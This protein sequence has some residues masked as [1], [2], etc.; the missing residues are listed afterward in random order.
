ILTMNAFEPL[1][2]MGCIYVLIRIIQ[3]FDSRLWIGFGALAGLGLM[4][5]HS[6]A[7]FGVA[8]VIGLLLTR[9]RK[10]FAKP[11]IWI[12]GAIALLIF[13]PNLFWQ[14]RHHSPTVEDLHNVRVTGK[15]VVLP[16]LQFIGQ[17]ILILNPVLFVV[18]IAGLWHFLVGGGQR[19]R[20]LGWIFLAFFSTMLV[21]HGKDYYVAPIYPILFAGG[22]VAWAN[23]LGKWRYTR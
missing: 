19:F 17:Q 14:I 10:E 15:N 16:P 3:T 6:T 2:W 9:Q 5:K 13:S 22:S 12:G 8:T 11:W 18:W 23:A 21:L 4:N 1:F 7:F 20:V